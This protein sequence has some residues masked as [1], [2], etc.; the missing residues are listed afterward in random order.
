MGFALWIEGD[1]VTAA[2]THEYRPMGVASI[3][4]NGTFTVRDFVRRRR[5][6]S[7]LADN[8]AGYF[9]S[10]GEMNDWLA[11]R[12]RRRITRAGMPIR[13]IL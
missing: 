3:A 9:A 1:V 4:S 2:G 6:P 10:L 12:Q 5:P 8:F 11:Q 13:A 7:R